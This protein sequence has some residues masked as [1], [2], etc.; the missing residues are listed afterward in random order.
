MP[1]KKKRGKVDVL[2]ET[3][4]EWKYPFRKETLDKHVCIAFCTR[5]NDIYW[6]MMNFVL[7]QTNIFKHLSIFTSISLWGPGAESLFSNLANYPCDYVVLIDTDVAPTTETIVRMIERDK[8]IVSC[9]AWMYDGGSEGDGLHINYHRDASYQRIQVPRDGGLEKIWNTSW[10]C[11]LLNHRV[12]ETFAQTNEG[13]TKWSPLIEKKWENLPPDSL[14]F[15]KARA[16]GF[17]VW[18]DWDCEFATHH[19]YVSLNAP[20]L[21]TFTKKRIF[22]MTEDERIGRSVGLL[23]R[24]QTPVGAG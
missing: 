11:C 7:E 19:K 21:E 20:T 18:M 9:P 23:A 1:K 5:G 22:G 24:R 4:R 16:L 8:D 15:E 2:A 12:L 14:F 6:K 10:A 17:D 13:Y 3:R